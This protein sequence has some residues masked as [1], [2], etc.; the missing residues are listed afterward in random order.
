MNN[1]NLEF[2]KIKSLQFLY[3]VNSNGTIFRN[4]KS[5]KQLKI[6]LDF[7]HSEKGYYATWV[8]IKNKVKRVMIHRVVAEC[9]RGECPPGMSVD[10]IDRNPH[11]NDYR[12]LRYATQSEQMKNRK[13]GD[14]VIK[15]A[16]ANV[17]KHT[18]EKVTKR[19]VLIRDGE[20]LF[21][22]SKSAAARFLQSKY[23]EKSVGHF[24][25]RI[26]KKR[27]HIYD[28]DVKILN[29]ETG[30]SSFTEQGTVHY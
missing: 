1:S 7:H 15:Q 3:E 24:F 4:V 13:L 12:N 29:A 11:N 16:T 18:Y 2:R 14:H 28:Y 19:T 5:K 20:E 30:H 10:H 6:K 26:N 27:S 25:N 9:W 17:L 8:N 23:P 21:F 22:I